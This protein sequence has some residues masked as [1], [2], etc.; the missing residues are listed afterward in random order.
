MLAEWIME[1]LKALEA[2]LPPPTGQHHSL[3][4]AQFGSDATG[5]EDKLCLG[6]RK[7]NGSQNYFLDDRDL[8]GYVRPTQCAKNVADMIR[9]AEGGR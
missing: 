8:V 3:T 5:W 2:E 9:A 6:F 4:F 1:F 7:S